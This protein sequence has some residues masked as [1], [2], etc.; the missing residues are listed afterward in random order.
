MPI[1]TIKKENFTWYYLTDFSENELA[2]LKSNFKFH[3]LDLK[4]C[5]GEIQRTKIDVY[6]NYLFLVFQLPV[7]EVEKKKVGISQVY[8]FIG[9]NYLVTITREK[10]KDLNVFFYKVLNGKKLKEDSFSKDTGY[11]FYKILDHL[12]RTSWTVHGIIEREIR[13][14][15]TEIDEGRGKKLVFNIAYLRRVILQLRTII[16]PQRLVTN[17]LSKIDAN[18]LSKEMSIYF[19]DVDDLIEK[20]WFLLEGYRDRILSLQEIN[21]SLISYQ[22]N[23]VMRILT[24]FSVALLPL[25]LLSGIYGMNIDVPFSNNPHLIWVLFGALALII[26]GLFLFLKRKDW[27]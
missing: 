2:F 12:L 17:T 3:P 4:D 7:L 6:K 27:I 13:R 24:V 11:L 26:I 19:D 22:T 15:E 23:Q 21:E 10:V 8:F 20:N 5:A 16:D 25:T 1:K 14:I 18:F 9:K